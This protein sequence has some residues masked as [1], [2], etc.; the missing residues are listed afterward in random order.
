[1][2]R[3]WQQLLALAPL[4]VL[5]CALH[6]AVSVN[7]FPTLYAARYAERCID[8]PTSNFGKVHDYSPIP[9]RCGGPDDSVAG[10]LSAPTYQCICFAL[11]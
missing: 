9:D 3:R 6:A 10:I 11:A 1:M 8:Q 4:L 5:A 7:S 2:A